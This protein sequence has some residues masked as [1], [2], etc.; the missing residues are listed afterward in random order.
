MR[1]TISHSA[2]AVTHL[3]QAH[4]V[5]LFLTANARLQ[6][7][8]RHKDGGA[9]RECRGERKSAAKAD[10]RYKTWARRYELLRCKLEKGVD[11]GCC[12]GCCGGIR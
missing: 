10:T 5:I 1:A 4:I 6:M 8:R 3:A 12:G 11:R 9:G 2:A 7:R